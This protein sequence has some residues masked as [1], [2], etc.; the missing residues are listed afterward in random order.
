MKNK[1]NETNMLSMTLRT[2]TNI[3]FSGLDFFAYF[4]SVCSNLPPGKIASQIFA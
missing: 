3:K 4:E 1:I 2:V